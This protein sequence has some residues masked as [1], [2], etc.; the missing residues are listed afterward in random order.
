[1]EKGDP[2][3]RLPIEYGKYRLEKRLG[4]GG[5]AEVFLA[6]HTGP[7]GF[8]R[9]TV[10]KRILP[11]LADDDRV[12]A[13][14]VAEARLMVEVRHKNVVHVYELDRL[15]NGEFFMA[16]EYIEGT[17]LANLLRTA[18][19]AQR[20]IPP[21]FS[22]KVACDLLEALRRLHGLT[23]DEGASRNVVHR[24]VTPSN[25]FISS[26]G[27]VKL[28]DFGVAK[29][30][31]RRGLTER[32]RV[33][34]KLPYMSPEQ[35]MARALDARADLFS[36]GVT[37]WEMLTQRRLFG[38]SQQS[39]LEVMTAICSGPRLP[40]SRFRKD[41][42][43][44][45]DACVLRALNPDPEG[46]HQT[47]EG[48]QTELLELLETLHPPIHS[49]DVRAAVQTL[50][51]KR[52]SSGSYSLPDVTISAR[53]GI[54]GWEAGFD[55]KPTET[56]ESPGDSAPPPRQGSQP[57]RPGFRGAH[58]FWIQRL[59]ETIGPVQYWELTKELAAAAREKEVVEV[60]VDGSSWI[61]IDTFAA[62]SG[63]D[64]LSP[65]E[66]DELTAESHGDFED[67]SLVQVLASLAQRGSTGRLRIA[68]HR[69]SEG[70]TVHLEGGELTHVEARA[71]QL[72]TPELMVNEG[73]IQPAEIPALIHQVL[74]EDAT[75]EELSEQIGWGDAA[76]FWRRMMKR[77]LLSV[78]EIETEYDFYEGTRRRSRRRVSLSALLPE[79]IGE[80]MSS[81]G[82]RRRLGERLAANLR[83]HARLDRRLDQ[84][85]PRPDQRDAVSM[86][87]R[88]G[89]IKNAIQAHPDEETAL[90]VWGYL[91]LEAGLFTS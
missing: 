87:R 76:A 89:S 68:G 60:S 48:M 34:G 52:P 29:D 1:M 75:L 31:G 46:R 78:L 41:I 86:L 56:S 88:A 6:R 28:G 15:P 21:W 23:D 26:F 47:A 67:F 12:E 80:G 62:R 39:D 81:V 14:F 3:R 43:P 37:L 57:S 44:S 5:M 17:D 19:R 61:D 79:L 65:I 90:L 73:L 54:A 32:G 64:S 36:L 53:G 18:T 22:V 13:D 8:E 24:D 69:N 35:L 91:L 40:P 10:I 9:P 20:R 7:G 49:D 58:P 74:S 59:G 11:E 2:I 50:L 4:K 72:Q 85:E 33:K 55:S 51:G 84:F 70:V 30:S 25:V 71:P 27:D 38:S 82:I 63:I 45:L 42:D 83:P 66:E 77:K 16:M